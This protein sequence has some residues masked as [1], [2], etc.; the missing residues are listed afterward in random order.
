ML[1][2]VFLGTSSFSADILEFLI[3]TQRF[4][5]VAVVSRPNKRQGRSKKLIDT[6]VR[7]VAQKYEIPCIQPQRASSPETKLFLEDLKPNFFVVAAYGEIIRP[8]ILE[9]PTTACLN[10]HTSLLPKYRGAAPIQRAILAGDK[11]TGVTIMHMVKELDAGDM[12]LQKE[13]IITE[14]MS[15]GELEQKL[16]ILGSELLLNSIELIIAGTAKKIAQEH[17]LSTYAKK[18]AV[19]DAQLIFNHPAMTIHNKI[20]GLN[21]KPGAWCMCSIDGEPKRIKLWKSSMQELPPAD[22]LGNLSQKE[23]EICQNQQKIWVFCQN[24]QAIQLLEVQIEG[25]KRLLVRDFLQGLGKKT[26]FFY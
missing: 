2:I 7:K 11:K 10:V 26:V 14:D 17:E 3:A 5:V 25:K 15:Y 1:K 20:R 23:G 18:I 4:E 19:E 16:C 13:C 22:L 24:Q 21:P 8:F 6:P 12:V 9:I